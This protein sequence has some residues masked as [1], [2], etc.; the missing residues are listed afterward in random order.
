MSLLK[1]RDEGWYDLAGKRHP[2]ADSDRSWSKEFQAREVCLECGKRKPEY[3][4]YP[5]HAVLESEPDYAPLVCLTGQPALLVRIDLLNV[6][7]E[8]MESRFRLGTVTDVSGEPYP[9]FVTCTTAQCLPLRGNHSSLLG[10]CPACGHI[11][12]Y[13]MPF[14][15]EYI[16]RD[17]LSAGISVYMPHSGKLVVRGDILA[18]IPDAIRRELRFKEIPVVEEARDGIEN[19]PPVRC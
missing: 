15:K 11:R 6:L 5:V 18:L 16:V 12:Y 8:F 10:S 17:S 2:V 1:I 3:A 19:F 4:D 14:G 9:D 7:R 13:P